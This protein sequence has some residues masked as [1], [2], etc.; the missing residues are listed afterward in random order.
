VVEDFADASVLA[1]F[2]TLGGFWTFTNGAFGLIFGANILYFL[3]S[4][5]DLP[6]KP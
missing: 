4:T 3:W 2:A 6:S 1:G 5:Y